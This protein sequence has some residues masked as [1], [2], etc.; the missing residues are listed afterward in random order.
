M[1]PKVAVFS[2]PNADYNVIFKRF[3]SLLPNGFR[4]TDHK[5]EWTRE[6]FKSWCTRVVEAYP[7][8]MFSTIGVGKPPKGFET[9]G[10]VS[11]IALFVRKDFFDMQLIDS[12]HSTSPSFDPK[13]A[14]KLLYSIDYPFSVDTRTDKEKVWSEVQFEIHR[15]KVDQ[16]NSENDSYSDQPGYKIPIAH[17]LARIHR[18]NATKDILFELFQEN[19]LEVDGDCV[20]IPESDDESNGSDRNEFSENFSQEAGMSDQDEECWDIKEY[21][22]KKIY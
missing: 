20:I 16:D 7:N 11:Q 15:F 4:H 18:V 19:A 21:P 1:Q 22:E 10:N 17:L 2:T 6:E 14:Y 5:F 8:Y 12:L 3:N 13:E 9:V